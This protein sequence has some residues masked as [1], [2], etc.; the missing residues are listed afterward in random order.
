MTR[1]NSDTLLVMGNLQTQRRSNANEWLL[2]A[3]G[4]YG[5]DSSVKTIDTLR[6]F[7]QFNHF[8]TSRLY[9]FGRMDGLH[10]GIKDIQYR[11]TASTG[12]GYYLMQRTNTSFIVEAGPALV[13]EEQG[14]QTET[15][16]ALRLAERFNWRLNSAAR[17]WQTAEFIPQAD[18]TA[19]FIINLEVGIET[20]ITKELSLRVSVQDN[21][22]N[23]P[24]FDYKNNDVRLVSGLSYKF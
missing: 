5:E 10:D 4:A 2:G 8:F 22:V 16:T 24:A 6:G 11:I 14:N 20:T 21:Y 17:L 15:Y 1:G 3:G 13:S 7:G 9:V 18:Q 12:L 23:E 19:N